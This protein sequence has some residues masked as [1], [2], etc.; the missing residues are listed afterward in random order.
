MRELATDARLMQIYW[1]TIE[2]LYGY[3]SRR[4]GAQRELAEDVT[5][6]A[7]LRAAREWRKKGIPET[8]LAWLTTVARNLVVD[9]LRR[10]EHVSLDSVSA[11]EVLTAVDH[12]DVTDSAEITT[13]VS[14]ALLRIPAA[15][16]KLLEAFHFEKR[17]TAQLASA[18]GVSDR[19]IEGRMRRARERLRR[20][21]EITLQIEER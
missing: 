18:Y 2:P 1:E 15:E 5:Q 20:E 13:A 7:W 4:C 10:T 6:E 9:Q 14:H 21:L 17:T 12:D 8:P 16:A 19:A 11:T 3:V